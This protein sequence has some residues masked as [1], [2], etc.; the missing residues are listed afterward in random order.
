[1]SDSDQVKT[2]EESRLFISPIATPVASDKLT[3]KLLK[4][5]K[6]MTK[7]K[8]VKKGIKETTKA[9]KKKGSNGIVLIAADISPVDVITHLPLICEAANIPYIYVPSREAIGGACSTKRPT[10]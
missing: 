8:K 2:V 9:T 5:T 1:M 7:D 4:L 3:T 10:A 6:K